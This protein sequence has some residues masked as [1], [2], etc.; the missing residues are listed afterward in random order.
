MLAPGQEWLT[1]TCLTVALCVLVEHKSL[2][3]GQLLHVGYSIPLML[4]VSLLDTQHLTLTLKSVAKWLD[5]K[6]AHL[7]DLFITTLILTRFMWMVLVLHED[8]HDNM[9]GL[10]QLDS[11]KTFIIQ[12]PA[13]TGP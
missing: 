10:T 8:H 5:T 7:M 11:T 9:C 6:R 12:V 4:H 1:S 3:V 2:S 13:R